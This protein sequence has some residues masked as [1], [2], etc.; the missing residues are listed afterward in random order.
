M[1]TTISVCSYKYGDLV[2][3][4]IE[5][6]LWQTQPPDEILVVDDGIGD[7]K[8][9]KTKYPEVRFI[10]NE[11]NLGVV[12]NFN[13]ILNNLV[14]TDR[15]LFLG[16]DNYLHPEALELMNKKEEDIVSCDAWI[17]GEG[18]Y[19][20]W[21]LHYQPHGSA[22]Y[23]VDFAQSVGG[24]QHSGH[25]NAEEDSELFKKMFEAGATFTRVDKPLLYYRR[26]RANYIRH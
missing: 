5:S 14:K 16:A 4:A 20:R 9:V 7:C 13:N 8:H 22:L 10:Q 23:N 19:R 26:H 18:K 12:D 25:E 2:S 21:T 6:V 3:Q 15:V 11:H 1:T 24:Y 17:V